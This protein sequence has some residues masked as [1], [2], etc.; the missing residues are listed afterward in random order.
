MTEEQPGLVR[1]RCPANALSPPALRAVAFVPGGLE[2]LH[3]AVRQ[4]E[5]PL[6]QQARP[7]AP[8]GDADD[9]LGAAVGE[10]Q[11]RQHDRSRRE[12]RAV[13]PIR[14]ALVEH[15]MIGPEE[16]GEVL[17]QLR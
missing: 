16:L 15:L 3:Q 12:G 9:L 10:G 5:L 6:V 7:Q 17:L 4:R 14:I 2:V 1:Q 11:G 13:V 8:L